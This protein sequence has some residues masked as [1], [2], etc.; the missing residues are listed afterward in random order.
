MTAAY[1][2]LQITDGSA[3]NTVD[4]VD[5]TNY[6]L[7]MNGWAPAVAQWRR[8]LLGGRSPYED[9]REEFTINIMGATAVACLANVEKLAIVLQNALKFRRT[10]QGSAYYV[11][12]QPQGSPLAASL[13]ALI[14]DVETRPEDLV[15]LP[16]TY[17]DHLNIFEVENARI[18]VTRRGVWLGSTETKA[19]GA[20][21]H[22]AK[23]TL[24]S[25]TDTVS[26]AS[27]FNLTADG[28][29]GVTSGGVNTFCKGFLLLADSGDKIQFIEAEA[30]TATVPG[31][32]TFA[33]NNAGKNARASGGQVRRLVPN[34]AGTYELSG[35]TTSPPTGPGVYS[36]FVMC[37]NNSATVNFSVTAYLR[38]DFSL[39]EAVSRPVVVDNST[40]NPQV[41]VL[42]PIA[43]RPAV[44]TLVLKF[45]P[46][47]TGAAETLDVDCVAMLQTGDVSRAIAIN[48]FN[49]V[50]SAGSLQF[51]HK[52]LS[53]IR[54]DFVESH[55]GTQY[56]PQY[57]GDIY[58]TSLGQ[59]ITALVLAYTLSEWR[60]V[61]GAI[62]GIIGNISSVLSATRQLGY[63]TPQ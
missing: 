37:Q 9:V 31:A 41:I 47:G 56:R 46:S 61:N 13:Q 43:Y 33:T 10:M 16:V 54:P 14:V 28:M 17:N 1:T 53:D 49:G 29:T 22:P 42:G 20:S 4:L 62:G 5:G 11:K 34:T 59:S 52:S 27:P 35:A 40:T 48:N 18:S 60:P 15:R 57:G 63:L 19:A 7:V 2:V 38:N 44:N 50:S 32:G 12:C 21:T 39:D 55:A 45:V 24:P 8:S 51:T 30:M 26:I 3:P 36:V 23:I 6:Q 25:F 58:L